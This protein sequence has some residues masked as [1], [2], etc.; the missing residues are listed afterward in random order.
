MDVRLFAVSFLTSWY[1]L[2]FHFIVFAEDISVV[3]VVASEDISSL[4]S[5]CWGYFGCFGWVYFAVIVWWIFWLFFIVISTALIFRLRRRV[6]SK[7]RNLTHTNRW[8]MFESHDFWHDSHTRIDIPT[9][10]AATLRKIVLRMA[11]LHHN[12]WIH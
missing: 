9:C 11:K 2:L 8:I 6:R 12:S 7:L 1:S 5:F 4:F 3:F 10:E